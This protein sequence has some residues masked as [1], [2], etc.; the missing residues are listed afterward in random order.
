MFDISVYLLA[1]TEHV[2]YHFHCPMGSR[3]ILVMT[4]IR[5][6]ISILAEM[7]SVRIPPA[8]PIN[9]CHG[10][11]INNYKYSIPTQSF[12]VWMVW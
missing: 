8:Q 1:M 7:I 9:L 4:L 5:F 12:I 3:M 11:G 10:R 6:F 2:Y